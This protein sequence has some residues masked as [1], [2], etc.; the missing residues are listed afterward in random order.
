MIKEIQKVVDRY[1][2]LD[3]LF[4]SMA[5]TCGADS[6]SPLWSAVWFLFQDYT[7]EIERKIG[8]TDAFL[9]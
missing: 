9:S 6:E 4:T 2:E 7:A 5:A 1:L 3:K 8:D